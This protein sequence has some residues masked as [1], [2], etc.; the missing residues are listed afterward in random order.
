MPWVRLCANF[1]FKKGDMK[2]TSVLPHFQFKKHT[3]MT[4]IR[5]VP[6]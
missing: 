5:E 3:R 4:D 2:R 6:N 1:D